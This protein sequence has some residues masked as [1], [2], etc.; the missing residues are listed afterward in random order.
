MALKI[1]SWSGAHIPARQPRPA[2]NIP[3][4]D[5][6]PCAS[7]APSAQPLLLGPLTIASSPLGTFLDVFRTPSALLHSHR[8]DAVFQASAPLLYFLISTTLRFPVVFPQYR[9]LLSIYS[10]WGRRHQ[11]PLSN[12]CNL[13]SLSVIFSST[14]AQPCLALPMPLNSSQDVRVTL[15]IMRFS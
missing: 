2:F 11:I 14:A 5:L 7:S 6:L 9:K 8:E 13:L 4:Y 1:R 15:I 12:S 3:C 10:H